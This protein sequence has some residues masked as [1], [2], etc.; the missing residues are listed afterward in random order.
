M[1]GRAGELRIFHGLAPNNCDS[2]TVRI[3]TAEL[4]SAVLCI[5]VVLL[6]Y[7]VD[8]QYCIFI[9]VH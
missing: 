3:E 1:R 9:T 5:A 4:A 6:R 8:L 2:T 7:T